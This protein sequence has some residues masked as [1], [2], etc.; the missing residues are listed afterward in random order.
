MPCCG[1]KVREKAQRVFRISATI[2]LYAT[3][4][5]VVSTLPLLSET[6]PRIIVLFASTLGGASH[7]D[8]NTSASRQDTEMSLVISPPGVHGVE[9][10]EERNR[11][12]RSSQGSPYPRGKGRRIETS[13]SSGRASFRGER[14][15]VNHDVD[16]SSPEARRRLDVQIGATHNANSRRDNGR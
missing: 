15:K 16:P 14:P 13:S 5:L 10:P 1:V 7:Q 8:E 2:F 6:R 12:G 3:I 11:A 4:F 9:E